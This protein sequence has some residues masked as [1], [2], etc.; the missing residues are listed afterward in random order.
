MRILH[1][2]DWHL[3]KKLND[4]DRF[5]E[6]QQVL[7]EIVDIVHKNDVDAVL[8]AGDVFDTYNP[9]NEAQ[10]LL[11]DTLQQIV[12]NGLCTV[13]VIAGNHDSPEKIEVI[14]TLA[15]QSGIFL[16]G[17]PNSTIFSSF[18]KQD[19]R[20]FMRNHAI[21]G[22]DEGFTELHFAKYDYNLRIIHTPFANGE[23]FRQYLGKTKDEESVFLREMLDGYWSALADK[24]CDNKGV[25]V[26]M[27]HQFVIRD[28]DDI[29]ETEPEDEHAINVGGTSAIY[30]E[31]FPQQIQYAALGHLHRNHKVG[32]RNIW[33][34]GSPLEYSFAETMQDKY[35]IIT[36]LEPGK[37]AVVENIRLTKGRKL[38]RKEFFDIPSAC[39]WLMENNDDLV[40]LTIHSD[41]YLNANDKHAL[42]DASDKIVAIIPQVN[43]TTETHRKSREI[44][45]LRS[46]KTELF[47]MYFKHQNNDQLPDQQLIDLFN[48]V[49]NSGE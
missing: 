25:N 8:L 33:Y 6:Q 41:T 10:K 28:E 4:K 18:P 27:A 17:Y 39:T 47:K 3:G 1:T 38:A 19:E 2:S 21:I 24:Y 36:D 23:R 5:E 16:L 48:E 29:S 44:N 30:T 14:K 31:N 13:F 22:M 40:E 49:I 37:E 42:Y 9:S 15:A 26:L 20:T 12:G 11:Y 43:S 35:V 7:L 34:S 32:S 46:D 45:N